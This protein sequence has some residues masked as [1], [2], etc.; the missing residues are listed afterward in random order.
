METGS[1]IVA[2]IRLPEAR[3][4]ATS[5]STAA[6]LP[7]VLATTASNHA[8]P[9]PS[10]HAL[11]ASSPPRPQRRISATQADIPRGA[12][13][14]TVAVI[15]APELHGP[16]PGM[17]QEP[18]GRMITIATYMAMT[19]ATISAARPRE[20]PTCSLQSG[21]GR[22]SKSWFTPLWDVYGARTVRPHA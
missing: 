21:S 16:L 14:F 19:P 9:R 7:L 22:R 10:R 4:A 5:H 6:W 12:I 20:V 2:P 13:G 1:G 11:A 18:C 15:T 8:R 17:L 3:N